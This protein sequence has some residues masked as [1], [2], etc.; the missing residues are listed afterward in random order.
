MP[1][2]DRYL[3]INVSSSLEDNLDSCL[4][5]MYYTDEEVNASGLNEST[6]SFYWYNDTDWEKLNSTTMDWVFGTGVE[7]IPN[8]VWANVS[9]FSIY[10]LGGGSLS[11][12]ID[13]TLYSGWNLIS[14]Y[15]T[16]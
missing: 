12:D 10:T 15:L 1:G 4:I 13:L 7:T 6:I 3:E 9:H 2:L 11:T 14:L 5:K 16:P 8:Y